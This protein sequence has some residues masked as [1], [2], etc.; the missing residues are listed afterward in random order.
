MKEVNEG[1]EF[2]CHLWGWDGKGKEKVRNRVMLG[3]VPP[4]LLLQCG[5]VGRLA[6]Q[7]IPV[8]GSCPAG[9][10][11]EPWIRP[12]VCSCPC[13]GPSWVE[14]LQLEVLE[15]WLQPAGRPMAARSRQIRLL[16]TQHVISTSVSA[17]VVIPSIRLYANFAYL[18]GN[19][20]IPWLRV[21]N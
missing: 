8:P 2:D 5:I 21:F 20:R 17:S 14:E 12:W 9:W 18:L 10:R 13:R 6:W 15:W 1:N 4:H 11:A 16:H 19:S 7:R 3:S